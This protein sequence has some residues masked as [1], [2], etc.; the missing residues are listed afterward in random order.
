MLGEGDSCSAW[1]LENYS[2]LGFEEDALRP[3]VPVTKCLASSFGE[4]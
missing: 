2:R 3:W 4:L 1:E